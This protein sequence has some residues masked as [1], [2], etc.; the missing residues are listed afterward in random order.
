MSRYSAIDNLA[1]MLWHEY[2]IRGY[3]P[4]VQD[5]LRRA[6]QAFLSWKPR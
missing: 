4:A 3:P 2:V 1:F 6:R 5:E